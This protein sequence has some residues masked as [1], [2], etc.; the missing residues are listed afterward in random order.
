M[1]MRQCRVCGS[2]L[3][4]EPLLTYEAM[5]AISQ[6][7]PKIGDISEEECVDLT[8]T[9]CSKCNLIQL[10]NDPVYYYRDVIRSGSVSLEVAKFRGNQ[11]QKFVD[12]YDLK[13]KKILEIGCGRGEYLKIMNNTGVKAYGLEHRLESVKECRDNGLSV[14]HGFLET[15]DYKVE[16]GPFDAFYICNFLEH[17]DEPSTALQAI[18]GNL[19]DDGIGIVEVPNTDLLIRDQS[20]YKFTLEHLLN[21][22]QETLEFALRLNGFDVLSC[23][24]IRHG[25]P[26]SAIVKKRK[27]YDFGRFEKNQKELQHLIIEFIDQFAGEKIAI[28]GAGHYTFGILAALNIENRIEYIVDSAP[29]KQGRCSPKTRVP[30]VSPETLK[31]NPVKGVLVSAAG[32][33]NEVAGILLS[34][35]DPKI[36]V[37]VIEN[38]KLTYKN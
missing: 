19:T 4:K 11:F 3:F 31:T 35:F 36:K 2:E 6:F 26:L 21:F 25:S 1:N 9:Q 37:A 28:W 16:N 23:K 38:N 13:G 24:P 33:S 15:A 34:Q 8:I 5:P 32:Y 22:T 20:F 10:D 18:S 29:F 30:I 27:R 7:L 12:E 17:F 14:I